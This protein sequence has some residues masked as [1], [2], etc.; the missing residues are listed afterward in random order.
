MAITFPCL[1]LPVPYFALLFSSVDYF[2]FS[3]PLSSS[4]LRR[5]SCSVISSLSYSE[6]P[7]LYYNTV[8][9]TQTPSPPPPRYTHRKG[10]KGGRALF[11]YGSDSSWRLL[12]S[13][14]YLGRGG[15]RRFPR[16]RRK[17]RW[18]SIGKGRR[19]QQMLREN[20]SPPSSLSISKSPFVSFRASLCVYS[21]FLL[22]RF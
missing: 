2:S 3:S 20:R 14:N 21:V 4:E 11:R 8:E 9:G 19:R 7:L 16:R 12:V 18:I 5:H 1:D 13:L 22:D 6:A 10:R 17:R 15:G